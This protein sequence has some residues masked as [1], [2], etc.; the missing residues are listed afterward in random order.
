MPFENPNF[1]AGGDIYPSRFVKLSASYDNTVT[2]AGTNEQPIGIS[3]DATRDAP[4]D[5][6]SGLAAADTN[7]LQVN[8]PGSVCLLEVGSGGLTRGDYVKSDTNGKGVTAATTGATAQFV[9]ALALESAS[10]GE[11][12]RVLVLFIPKFYPA[13]S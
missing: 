7:A 11:L 5:G 9:G 12:A 1:T 6:A 3:S 10:A 13:L 4:L 8:L 2:Q